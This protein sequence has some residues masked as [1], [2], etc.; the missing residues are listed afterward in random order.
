MVGPVVLS[1]G[2]DL[3]GVQVSAAGRRRVL[4]VVVDGDSGVP[5]DTVAEVSRR[6]HA[7]AIGK[8]DPLAADAERIF[9]P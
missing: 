6:V 9:M 2:L 7:V 1:V 8:G 5:L 3:E 4:R